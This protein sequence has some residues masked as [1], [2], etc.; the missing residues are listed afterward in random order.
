MRGYVFAHVFVCVYL[1]ILYL[2]KLWLESYE[3]CKSKNPVDC[4]DSRPL[5]L[6]LLSANCLAAQEEWKKNIFRVNFSFKGE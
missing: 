2:D 5:P 6:A 4:G 1:F 3:I